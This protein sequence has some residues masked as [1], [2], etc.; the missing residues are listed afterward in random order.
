MSTAEIP[1]LATSE[2]TPSGW[3]PASTMRTMHNVVNALMY[4][5]SHDSLTGALTKEAIKYQTQEFIDAQIPFG[6]FMMDWDAFKHINDELG[7]ETADEMLGEFGPYFMENFQRNGEAVAHERLFQ[8]SDS[9]HEVGHLLGR[10]GGDEFVNLVNLSDRG[11]PD[12]LTPEQRMLK[13][14]QHLRAVVAGFV[15]LQSPEVRALKYDISIGG[16]I[17]L[18]GSALEVGDVFRVADDELRLDKKAHHAPER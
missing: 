5:A 8:P 12:G 3:Y 6:L 18:P 16:A 17:W 13:A 1:K 14:G 11:Q 2:T 9:P 15:E 10:Y 4:F 7:H